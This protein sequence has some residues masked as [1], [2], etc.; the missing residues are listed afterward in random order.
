MPTFIAWVRDGANSLTWVRWGCETALAQVRRVI[1]V[2]GA[3]S[4]GR[5]AL[6]HSLDQARRSLK[7]TWGQVGLLATVVVS[8]QISFH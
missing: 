7:K 6:D 1:L 3:P 5:G 4:W 2:K 8:L